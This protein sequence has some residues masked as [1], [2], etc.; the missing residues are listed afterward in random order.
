MVPVDVTLV[1]IHT[2]LVHF[3]APEM[4]SNSF[5]FY[6]RQCFILQI[7]DF[8]F[9]NFGDVAGALAGED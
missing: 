2:G 9:Y 5:F 6:S 7:L 3:Q 8:T 4:F 1:H